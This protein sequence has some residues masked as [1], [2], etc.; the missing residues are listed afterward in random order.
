VTVSGR[1]AEP[2]YCATCMPGLGEIAALEIRRRVPGV[3]ILR[4]DPDCVFLQYPGPTDDL[5]ALRTAEDI[6]AYVGEIPDLPTGETGLATIKARVTEMDLE[7][8]LALHSGLHSPPNP[9]RF[10]VTAT[11]EGKH[12]YR[13]QDAAGAAGA[14]VVAQRGWPVDL[15]AH[16][17]DIWLRIHEGSAWVGVRLSTDAMAGRAV[18][19]GIASLRPTVAHAMCLLSDPHAG[20]L[21]LDPMCGTGTILVERAAAGPI[22]VLIG[23]DISPRAL[24]ETPISLNAADVYARLFRGDS[25][26]MPFPAGT[27]DKI[28][29]NP[30]WGCRVGS[31]A[32]DRH[33][34]PRFLD[35]MARVAKPGALL[36]L[37]TAEK[38]LFLRCVELRP[39]L[40]LLSTIRVNIN[41]IEPS[42]YVLRRADD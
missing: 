25:G 34:Y 40:E 13:S 1:Q 32:K 22:P 16:D 33:L 30:P 8:A 10:R 9:P 29:S 11:R 17:L 5:L 39:Q 20:E 14:A 27:I 31:H 6:C 2:S 23:G 12:A 28:I 21:V 42:I 38:R 35:E 24:R 19:T 37:I 15:T 4:I 18:I 26:R 7:P 36:V 41:G 3:Q